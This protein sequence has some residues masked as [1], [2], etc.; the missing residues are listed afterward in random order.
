MRIEVGKYILESDS[1]C[2]WISEMRET[3]DPR[4]GKKTGKFTRVR[5]AGYCENI[6]ELCEDFLERRTRSS[7]AES[8]KEILKDIRDGERDA[9][10]IL[11]AMI[12]RK[13][14]MND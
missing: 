11:K 8:L 10:A 6:E 2:M 5:V 13:E 3:K 7:D 1:Y 9:K 4:T 12:K 14:L